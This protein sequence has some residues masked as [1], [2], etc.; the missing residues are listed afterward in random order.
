MTRS[1]TSRFN[2]VFGLAC[3]IAITWGVAAVVRFPRELD[4]VFLGE[5]LFY[6]LLLVW[7]GRRPEITRWFRGEDAR[8]GRLMLAFVVLLVAGQLIAD[9]SRS[10]PFVTWAMY[11]K[12][13]RK[14]PV[15]LE[16]HGILADGSEVVIPAAQMFQGLGVRLMRTW[17]RLAE[18]A[19]AETVPDAEAAAW[20]KFDLLVNSLALE[21]NRMTPE[22]P[23]VET[24]VWRVMIP[25]QSRSESS[26]FTRDVLR[27]ADVVEGESG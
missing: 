23:V 25:I 6:A 3:V 17:L 9:S 18:D 15:F 16:C 1:H 22:A 24:V 2:P 12:P 21:Y 7:L 11:S 5:C 8:Y 14:V 19:E 4:A 13:A 27:R 10:Y 20:R 26:E